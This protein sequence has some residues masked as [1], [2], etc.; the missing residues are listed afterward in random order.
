[1]LN[2]NT[3]FTTQDKIIKAKVLLQNENPFFA[4]ILSQM[5]I[6]NDDKICSD[7]KPMGVD[8]NGN[9]FYQEKFVSNIELNIL[10]SILCH[11]ALHVALR[12]LERLGIKE[13]LTWNIATDISINNML[14]QNGFKML[15][16]F[17][18]PEGNEIR[19]DEFNVIITDISSKTAN[20]IYQILNSKMKQ[21]QKSPMRFDSHLDSDEDG[22]QQPQNGKDWEQIIVEAWTHSQMKGHLPNGMKRIIDSIVKSKVNWK[23]LLQQYVMR[24]LPID[25]NWNY[26]S[27]RS[28]STGFYLPSV[29]RENIEIVVTI[30]TS[31]SISD[32]VIKQF[33]SEVV[34]IGKSSEHLKATVLVGDTEIQEIIPVENGNIKK[35]LNAEFKGGGG[36]DHIP[37]YKWVKENKP[38][39]K[40]MVNLTDGYTD[41][42]EGDLI[43]NSIWVLTKDV[44]VP[45][46][47]KIVIE[48]D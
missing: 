17:L 11:E 24:E 39:C 18:V 14:V 3:N 46:G 27:K 8:K 15:K 41:F 36:T 22:V 26:P 31:G 34:A 32:K 10:K 35:L 48:G 20:E 44:D 30:D 5:K 37:F 16:G 40:V 21:Q 47:S 23:A 38:N 2:I 12:H 9:L 29:L 6:I 1:M 42:P 13:R 33:L 45:F 25:W 7:D 4:Y 28:I 43:H 19:L